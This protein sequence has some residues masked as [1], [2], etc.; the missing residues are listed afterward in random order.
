M[1]ADTSPPASASRRLR[2]WLV[3]MEITRGKILAALLAL[4]YLATAI[5]T[6]GWD[7]KG[8]AAICFC[9][10]LTLALI[11]FPE[12]IGEM[13]GHGGTIYKPSPPILISFVGW[14]FLLVGWPLIAY[15]L[16]R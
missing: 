3:V 1:L 16:T 15:L 14:L 11:W 7:A 10:A 12:E 8:V 9:L 2:W 13:L 5:A 4:V 6:A